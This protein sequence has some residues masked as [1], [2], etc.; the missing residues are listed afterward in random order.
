HLTQGTD[1]IGK[2]L[3]CRTADDEVEHAGI[4]RHGGGV[5]MSEINLDASVGGIV[6]GHFHECSTDVEPGNSI[7]SQP[8]QLDG[9]IAGSG[10]YFQH[11]ATW[12]HLGSDALGQVTEFGDALARV[13]CVPGRDHALHADTP[14]RL[15]PR[16]GP[17]AALHLS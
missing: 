9:E 16:P 4:K 1:G 7:V 14:V 15:S 11:A 8:R 12:P 6:A 17:H 2:V 10:S 13:L 5:A 3:E